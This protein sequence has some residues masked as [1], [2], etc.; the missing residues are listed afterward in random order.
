MN[1]TTRIR[2]SRPY[3]GGF[4]ARVDFDIDGDWS[5]RLAAIDGVDGIL[6]PGGF[7]NRGIEGKITPLICRLEGTVEFVWVCNSRYSNTP[8]CLRR[9]ARRRLN[10]TL[11][12]APVIL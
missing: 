10:S 11:S 2:P 6:V 5:K 12:C 8:K 9:P 3:F 7:G 1:H 4:G